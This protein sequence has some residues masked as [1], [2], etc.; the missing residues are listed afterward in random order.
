MFAT[1]NC[2]SDRIYAGVYLRS[3]ASQI[4]YSLTLVF[5]ISFLKTDYYTFIFPM[6][7]FQTRGINLV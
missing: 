5:F 6:H 7:N 1:Q 3:C 2:S 4:I